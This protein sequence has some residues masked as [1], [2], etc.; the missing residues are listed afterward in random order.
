[1]NRIDARFA[2]LKDQKK[3]AFV[4]YITAGDPS[5]EITADLVC[6]LDCAGA[7]VVELGI[8]FSDPLAD[9]QV[10]QLAAQRALDA[11]T[12]IEDIFRIVETLRKRSAV[13]LVLFT[14]YNPV[15][16][17]GNRRFIEHSVEAGVDGILLLDLPPEESEQIDFGELRRIQLIAPTT[18][19]QRVRRLAELASGFIYYVSREGVTGMQSALASG[20]AEKVDVVRRYASCPIC[21][22]FGISNPT[23]AAEVAAVADGVVVGSALV[24]FIA[25]C[26][27]QTQLAAGLETFARPFAIATHGGVVGNPKI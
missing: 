10:N 11:G 21:V 6:A 9:G 27:D 24:N 22:G 16:R 4:A 13:P 3:A 18:P 19:E 8:P 2:L 14:Y 17:Y 7:D 26:K 5:P 15:H 12:K 25:Q 1:M 23:Q 20:L